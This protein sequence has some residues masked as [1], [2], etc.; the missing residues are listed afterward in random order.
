MPLFRRHHL[1]AC[2][3]LKTKS[4]FQKVRSQVHAGK[5]VVLETH[6]P[7]ESAVRLAQELDIGVSNHTPVAEIGNLEQAVNENSV[8][9]VGKNNRQVENSIYMAELTQA[10]PEQFQVL[11]VDGKAPG[12]GIKRFLDIFRCALD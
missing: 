1:L 6:E 3:N 11:L 10:L 12:V 8:A 2:C 5:N 7:E 9:V 4:L